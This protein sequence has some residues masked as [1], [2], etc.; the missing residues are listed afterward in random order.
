[1]ISIEARVFTMTLED[2]SGHFSCSKP[3]R[4]Q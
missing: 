1:M 2:I 3:T 4:I